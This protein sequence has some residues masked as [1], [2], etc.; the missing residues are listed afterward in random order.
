M[1]VGFIPAIILGNMDIG[2]GFQ[3]RLNVNEKYFSTLIN[4]GI[5][6]TS[7]CPETS[8]SVVVQYKKVEQSF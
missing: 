6:S 4:I 2:G 5:I 8:L 1:K 3:S 7:G